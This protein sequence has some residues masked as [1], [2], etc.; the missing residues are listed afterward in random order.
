MKRQ[1][2]STVL[3]YRKSEVLAGEPSSHGFSPEEICSS[4]NFNAPAGFSHWSFGVAQVQKEFRV[5]PLGPE[6]GALR[7]SGI[8]QSRTFTRKIGSFSFNVSVQ[9]SG[10]QCLPLQFVS[11]TLNCVKVPPLLQH[12]Y[13][14]QH[15]ENGT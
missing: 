5:Q 3:F 13:K 14:C 11:I 6:I 15:T 2:S 8:L 7:G 1:F 4:R 12:Q 9:L 10:I